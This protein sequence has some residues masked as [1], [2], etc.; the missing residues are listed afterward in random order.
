MEQE[1]RTA[2]QR[3]KRLAILAVAMAW[4]ASGHAG[5]PWAQSVPAQPGQAHY[6][7][8]KPYQFDGVWY[9]PAVDYRYDQV[10]TASVYPSGRAGFGTTS[11][12]SYSD[13]AIT[14][15]HK[16]LPL[17]TLVKVTNLSNGKS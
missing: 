15:A 11:G 3:G 1:G 7:L 2:V 10:G 8:G 13:T 14:G 16:T 12:E 4:A 5:L 9:Q 17:P 6:V